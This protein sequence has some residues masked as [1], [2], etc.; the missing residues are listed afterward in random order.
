MPWWRHPDPG[1]NPQQHCQGV[2]TALSRT[3]TS[4]KLS[5]CTKQ[6]CQTGRGAKLRLS[7]RWSLSYLTS[8][9]FWR[10]LSAWGRF[11]SP[12]AVPPDA[13]EIWSHLPKAVPSRGVCLRST[14]VAQ[15]PHS[16]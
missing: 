6:R 3:A 14:G 12:F 10:S 15:P 1:L 16:R 11:N 13:P 9:A 2:C 7:V 8:K 4:F 5:Q